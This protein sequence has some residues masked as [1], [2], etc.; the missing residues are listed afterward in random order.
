MTLADVIPFIDET[1]ALGVRQFSCTGGEPFVVRDVP[2]ILG[3]ALERGSCLVLTNGTLPLRR[4]LDELDD[5]LRKPH[6]RRFRISLDYPSPER[7]DAGRG[8]GTFAMAL[9]TPG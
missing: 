4:R 1:V 9:E 3:Y 2:T 8:E 6:P 5:L 7:H